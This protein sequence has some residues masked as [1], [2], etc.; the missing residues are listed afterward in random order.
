MSMTT[1]CLAA[2]CALVMTAMWLESPETT[3]I[4]SPRV[5]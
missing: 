1:A 3:P 5:G 2:S 4:V